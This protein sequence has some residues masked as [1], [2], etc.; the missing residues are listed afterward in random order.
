MLSI[1]TEKCEIKIALHLDILL[2]RKKCVFKKPKTNE[3]SFNT[4]LKMALFLYGETYSYTYHEN[5]RLNNSV[6]VINI[7]IKASNV[8]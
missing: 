3:G 6:S 4:Y 8:E 7:F 5:S 2:L 1:F